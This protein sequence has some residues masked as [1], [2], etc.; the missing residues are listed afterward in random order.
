[1]LSLQ[2]LLGIADPVFRRLFGAP[3]QNNDL[4]G[5][6]GAQVSPMTAAFAE[7]L[8]MAE[9]CGAIFDQ[10]QL[11]SPQPPRGSAALKR[12]AEIFGGP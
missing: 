8:D 9:P 3:P 1:V 11:G 4:C 5:W 2:Y 10:P 6:I 7:R 12:Q